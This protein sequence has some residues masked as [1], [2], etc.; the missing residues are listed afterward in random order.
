MSVQK[1]GFYIG[2]AFKL[3]ATWKDFDRVTYL[4]PDSQ[5]VKVYDP[6]GTL[7]ATITNPT[8]VGSGVYYITYSTS[9]TDSEGMWKVVWKVTKDSLSSVKVYYI[10]AVIP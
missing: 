9:S 4:V 8:L 5:E 2:S 3:Q 10:L 6:N 1:E 7:K